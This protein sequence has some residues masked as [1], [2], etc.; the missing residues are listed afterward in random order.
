M[1]DVGSLVLKGTG[2][3]F[4]IISYELVADYVGDKL[5]VIINR[6]SESRSFEDVSRD[7]LYN[8]R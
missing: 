6:F 3:V 8:N 5:S 1:G 4:A 7:D 2:L